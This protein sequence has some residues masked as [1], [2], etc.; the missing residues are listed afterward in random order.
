MEMNAATQGLKANEQHRTDAA[1]GVWTPTGKGAN[2]VHENFAGWKLAKAANG[3]WTVTNP[4]DEQL[5]TF[6]SLAWAKG[7]A[8]NAGA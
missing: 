5:G 3:G 1:L 6:P 7:A 4:L 2:R 8:E